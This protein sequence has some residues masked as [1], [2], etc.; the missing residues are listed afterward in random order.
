MQEAVAV[1]MSISAAKLS[2]I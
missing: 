1:R 2:H